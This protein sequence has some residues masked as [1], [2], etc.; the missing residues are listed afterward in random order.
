MAMRLAQN[1]EWDKGL[2]RRRNPEQADGVE[3]LLRDALES[4]G[5]GI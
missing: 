2:V 5:R 3:D 4:V 1:D